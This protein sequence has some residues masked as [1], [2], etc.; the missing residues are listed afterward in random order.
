MTKKTIRCS[1]AAR[2]VPGT[3]CEG[4]PALL[5]VMFI[6]LA[7]ENVNIMASKAEKTGVTLSGN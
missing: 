4:L 6:I 5:V 3:V 1:I 7:L 2:M